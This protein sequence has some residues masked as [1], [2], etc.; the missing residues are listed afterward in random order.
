MKKKKISKKLNDLLD[1]PKIM[2]RYFAKVQHRNNRI[3]MFH[4]YLNNK[5]K[6]EIIQIINKEIERG[7]IY[8]EHHPETQYLPSSNILNLLFNVA[9]HFGVKYEAHVDEFDEMFNGNTVL[10]RGLKFNWINGQGTVR[11]IID[12][13]K[14][15]IT[16]I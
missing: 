2:E 15:V 6:T 9:E 10:Y 1:D 7:N 16:E 11:R 5:S 13:N 12:G 4:D 3:K 14:T 8:F